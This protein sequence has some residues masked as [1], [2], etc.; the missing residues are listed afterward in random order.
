MSNNI[1]RIIEKIPMMEAKARA[2]LRQNADEILKKTPESEDAQRVIDALDAFD[3]GRPK[4]ERFDI[5]GLLAWEKYQ[6]GEAT[7]FRAFYGDQVVGR[8]IKNANHSGTE[9]DVYSVEILGHVIP[10]AWHHISD[11]RLAG[12]TAFRERNKAAKQ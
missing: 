8:I 2:A 12:E 6:K 9:K 4:A 7:P 3:K 5:T 11:A 1:D 10:G